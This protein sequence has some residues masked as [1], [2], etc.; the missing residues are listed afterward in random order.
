MAERM[1]P[2]PPV[3]E[4]KWTYERYLREAAA[5][6]YFTII[7]GEKIVSPSQ[8]PLLTGFTRAVKD[9]FVD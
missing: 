2:P 5:G 3:T 9:L 8:S 1:A 6:E 7:A 4:D